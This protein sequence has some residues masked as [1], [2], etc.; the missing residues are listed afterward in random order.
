MKIKP[1]ILEWIETV[2]TNYII[3]LEIES[4]VTF[5]S[6]DSGT[7]KS[8]VFSFLW[9]YSSEDDKIICL[10]YI[11]HNKEYR[12]SIKKSRGKLFVIDNADILLDDSMRAHIAMDTENQY[13]IMG[14]NPSSLLLSKDDICELYSGR[15]GDMI[16]F[17][18]KKLLG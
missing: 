18:L 14:R 5:I 1:V 9:E 7:G 17:K 8:A 16:I 15:N 12:E 11:D 13:I 2:H 4:N 6:G 10:N 3:D